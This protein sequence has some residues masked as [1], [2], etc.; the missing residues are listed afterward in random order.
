MLSVQ[1]NNAYCANCGAVGHMYKSCNHPV[2][3]FGIICYRLRF[4]EHQQCIYPEY[5]M[6]QRKDSLCYVEFVRGKFDIENKLYIFKLF[7][8]MTVNER[9]NIASLTFEELW[10]Q[11]W[12]VDD[13]NA[14][15]REYN[16]AKVKF[17]LL[18]N[19]Y[20]LTERSGEQL[21]C[22]I[23]YVLQN[24]TS[25]LVESEWGFPK[26]RRNINEKDFACAL[27]EFREESGIGTRAI[28]I[29][30][31]QKPF[32]EIFTGSNHIRYR[33]VYYLASTKLHNN[34]NTNMIH[35]F[36][37]QC[38]TRMQVRE[39]RD[40]QWFRYNDVQSH[41]LDYNVERKELFRRVNY[42]VMKYLSMQE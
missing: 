29:Q 26:G 10:K 7:S 34:T 39:I 8:N 38:K 5:L 25:Q 42:I 18:K 1:K 27:R 32:D 16:D 4:D 20:I 14:F 11:L 24:T 19:G 36:H 9:S 28:K 21:F 17:E 35:G 13:C 12:Q 22:D 3:S 41:I 30:R 6:V 2:T 33:H 15:Q 37:N 31:D 23:D 40:V